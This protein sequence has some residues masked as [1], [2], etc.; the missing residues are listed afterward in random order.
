MPAPLY[1]TWTHNGKVFNGL[2]MS[3]NEWKT[4]TFHYG[5]GF[6]NRVTQP[7]EILLRSSG[8]HHRSYDILANVNLRL[9]GEANVVRMLTVDWPAEGFGVELSQDRGATYQLLTGPVQLKASAIGIDA[10]DG[11]LSPFDTATLYV[12]VRVPGSFTQYGRLNFQLELE[13]DVR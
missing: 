1:V 13:C 7:K 6:P 8:L 10:V 2:D 12:R 9:S 5:L 3:D 11:E 4:E